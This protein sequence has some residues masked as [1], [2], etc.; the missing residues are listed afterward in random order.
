MKKLLT[1]QIVC[2]LAIVGSL[3]AQDILRDG[4]DVAL[5]GVYP[6]APVGQEKSADAKPLA[7]SPWN[8]WTFS[9]KNGSGSA[10]WLPN[11]GPNAAFGGVAGGTGEKISD[12]QKNGAVRIQIQDG[13][14]SFS[15][16]KI[17]IQTD[18]K[19]LVALFP[20]QAARVPSIEKDP[21]AG[22]V[23][24]RLLAFRG[25]ESLSGRN[26]GG[27]TPLETTEWTELLANVDAERID[28]FQI[29]I[30][31]RGES[32]VL[33]S[34]VAVY[35]GSP[36]EKSDRVKIEGS[37][38]ARTDEKLDRGLI[39]AA[40]EKGV[41]LSWRFLPTDNEAT[42]FLLSRRSGEKEPIELAEKPIRATTDFLD[43]DA[44]SGKNIWTVRTLKNGKETGEQFQ[45]TLDLP[46]AKEDRKD[47]VSIPIRGEGGISR[48]ALADLDGDGRLDYVVKTP[49]KNVDPYHRP[50]YWS[51]SEGTFTV[52]AYSADGTFLWDRDLGWS[53]E[54]G[55]WYSPMFVA[56]LDGDNRAE[57]ALKT[58]RGD[59]RDPSGRVH[60]REEFLTVLDGAT[61]KTLDEI[62]WLS[63]SGY[64]YNH[65]CRNFLLAARLDGKTPFLIAHR[66]TYGMMRTAAY[67]LADKKLKEVWHFGNA[68]EVGRDTWGQGAHTMHAVDLDN[69][70]REEIAAGSFVFDDDGSI[71]WSLGL[72]H[73]DHLYVGEL[74]PDSDGM[75]IYLG[76]E[77]GNK[78]NGLTMVKAA[79]GEKLWGLDR[80][81]W[82]IHSSGLCADIDPTYPGCE[83]FGGESKNDHCNNR[84]LYSAA[85]KLLAVGETEKEVVIPHLGPRTA[86][87]DESDYRVLLR[88]D[89]K[90]GVLMRVRFPAPGTPTDEFGAKTKIEYL[91]ET[92]A[93]NVLLTGDY[94][95]DWRE[96]IVT[97]VPGELRIYP[98]TI[99]AV[100]RR[101]TLLADP[102]YRASTLEAVMGYWQSPLPGS[103]E[104]R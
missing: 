68:F 38:K 50:G 22:A 98:T 36:W 51:Q 76:M 48:V 86:W 28:A 53:I 96:E 71:L 73:P 49:N 78:E 72:G 24:L 12:E 26:A 85:G 64:S 33:F 91:P 2:L 60:S 93:G 3:S 18:R 101:V 23:N 4:K 34:P 43:N 61:G 95:G 39:A 57:V 74:N 21:D 70:G 84:Y 56:D 20:L 19:K 54:E 63:R 58:G 67:E 59:P 79:T 10:D 46:E 40:S 45:T 66:G 75:E 104:K 90:K 42:E 80:Q 99:P 31:G 92:F 13:E 62:P 30:Y 82:H 8:G 44:P 14:W 81:S 83:C 102:S 55:I 25:K 52:A 11:A 103:V 1:V 94:F 32:N 15:S 5:V 27:F 69:D 47:Y 87:R 97:S 9:V 88:G 35:A 65:S 17:P 7:D 6:N 100:S 89:T 29:I 16:P 77:T 41:T 37:A